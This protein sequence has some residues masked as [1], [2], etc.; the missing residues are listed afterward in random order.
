MLMPVSHYGV[1]CDVRGVFRK[2]FY[3]SQTPRAA[4]YFMQIRDPVAYTE[5]T[6]RFCS[7]SVPFLWRMRGVFVPFSALPLP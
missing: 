7:V 6:L 2:F 3:A 4:A 5:Y 1:S